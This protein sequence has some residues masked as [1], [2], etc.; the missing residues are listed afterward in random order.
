MH[1]REY[2]LNPMVRTDRPQRDQRDESPR[3]PRGNRAA[4]YRRSAASNNQPRG[5]FMR[6]TH[7]LLPTEKKCEK[8]NLSYEF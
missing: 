1:N 2:V 5:K 8:E 4:R 6:C 3:P 7:K